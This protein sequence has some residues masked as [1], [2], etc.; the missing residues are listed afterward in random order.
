MF[1][2]TGRPL[3]YNP[4]ML[5]IMLSGAREGM[6]VVELSTEIGISRETFNQWTKSN[7]DFSDTVNECRALSQ[8]WWEAL[9]RKGAK[10]GDINPT[11]WIFNM[12]NRFKNEWR[13]KQ[14]VEQSGTVKVIGLTQGWDDEASN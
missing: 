4:E 2:K 5:P 14:E 9:G 10:N 13:D 3:K 6:G 8:S 12:K 1:M 7:K 11:V